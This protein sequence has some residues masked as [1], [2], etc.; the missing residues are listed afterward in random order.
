[1]RC[2]SGCGRL[3]ERDRPLRVIR[4]RAGDH[5]NPTVHDID[6]NL[7]DATLFVRRHRRCLTSASTWHEE[8]HTLGYLPLDESTECL[9]V[10]GAIGGKRR[11]ERGAAAS[12]TRHA[13][14]AFVGA[15]NTS[16]M[17]NTP[18]RPISHAAATSAP[19]A[20]T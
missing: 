19:S 12:E 4:R 17:V 1:M 7:D 2:A 8:V 6:D 20:K 14:P 13:A 16:R 15:V 5:W 18:L 3:G 11:H 9:L 10:D